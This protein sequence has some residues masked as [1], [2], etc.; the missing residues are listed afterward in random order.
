MDIGGNWEGV[1]HVSGLTGNWEAGRQ[2]AQTRGSV[3]L[4]LEVVAAAAEVDVA[5][6][7]RVDAVVEIQVAP[8]IHKHLPPANKTY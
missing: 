8:V 3:E 6:A 4:G 7:V 5:D 1:V 2:E